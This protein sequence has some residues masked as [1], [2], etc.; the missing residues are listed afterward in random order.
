MLIGGNRLFT[1]GVR[2]GPQDCAISDEKEFRKPGHSHVKIPVL[3]VDHG[4]ETTHSP[5]AVGTNYTAVGEESVHLT[6][7]TVGR[8]K[9]TYKPTLVMKCI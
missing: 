6:Q 2:P 4:G 5:K 1:C 8:K 9:E 3:C 7:F